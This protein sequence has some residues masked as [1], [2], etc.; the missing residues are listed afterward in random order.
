MLS[1]VPTPTQLECCFFC[2]VTKSTLTSEERNAVEFISWTNFSDD[3]TETIYFFIYLHMQVEILPVLSL[4]INAEK[5]NCRSIYNIYHV[6]RM[7]FAD[8]ICTYYL[9][10]SFYK[11]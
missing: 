1:A 2:C 11:K 4:S 6:F 8:A 5:C 3:L 9:R 7:H 10:Y